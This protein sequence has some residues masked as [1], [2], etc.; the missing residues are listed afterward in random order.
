MVFY[1]FIY[2]FIFLWCS[3]TGHHPHEDLAK[4]GNR[5][6]MKGIILL[7]P[8]INWATCMNAMQKYGTFIIIIIL[9]FFFWNLVN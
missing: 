8:F 1:L 6:D 5:P 4:F 2:L 7:N 3:Q 9:N